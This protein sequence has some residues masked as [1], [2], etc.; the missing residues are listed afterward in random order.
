MYSAGDTMQ[1]EIPKLVQ[2]R[3]LSHGNVIKE[4]LEQWNV[5]M[6]YF[7]AEPKTEK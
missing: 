7:Q 6:P 5:M 3:L 1:N 2:T 4:M